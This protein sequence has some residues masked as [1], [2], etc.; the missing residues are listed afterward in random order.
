MCNH[1]NARNPIHC[2]IPPYMVDKLTRSK[3]ADV[4]RAAL[5]TIAVS[6]STRTS[7]QFLSASMPGAMSFMGFA[8][9]AGVVKKGKQRFVYVLDNREPNFMTLPG[10][11]AWK[12]G[13]ARHADPAVYEAY[14]YAGHTFDFFN[15]IFR[16]ISLDGRGMPL[17]STVHAGHSF[18]NA[19]WNG[20]QMV[21]GDGDGAVF[22]RF[23]RSID[24]VGHELTHGVVQ[25]TSALE[26]HDEPGALNEHFA[27]VFGVLVRQWKKGQ[28]NPKTADW[29][30]GADLI[31]QAPTRRA[32]R[33]MD[34]PGSA[35][36]ND[37]D[38]GDD[39]QPKHYSHRFQGPNDE[40]HDWGGVHINSGI[41][42]HAFY[43]TATAL[44]G[45]AWGKAGQIWY[46]AMQNLLP[47]S[48]FID[49]AQQTHTIAC[50]QF[51]ENS[52]EQQAVGDA[53]SAVG[54]DLA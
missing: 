18:N 49:C 25:F 47:E 12:E 39:P 43:L 6:A 35:F 53:W 42:N 48:Q 1:H 24:V 5:E 16:R 26:Y 54:I 28:K 30:I 27:D 40:F 38:L 7:R 22:T 8:S 31:V 36:A 11:L 4:R 17:I 52:P 46:Q 10:R 19:F 20:R 44:S 14:T 23:T 29:L 33:S 9:A 41:P 15:K 2:I 50:G 51:G 13:D 32:L 21:Y 34:D 37:P 45:P 3:D